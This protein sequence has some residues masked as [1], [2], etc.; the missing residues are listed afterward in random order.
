MKSDHERA[1]ERPCILSDTRLLCGNRLVPLDQ[2]YI[3]CYSYDI[4]FCNQR[5]IKIAIIDLRYFAYLTARIAV[6]IYPVQYTIESKK[7]NYIVTSG[8]RTVVSIEGCTTWSGLWD[9]QFINPRVQAC[10]DEIVQYCLSYNCYHEVHIQK[11]VSNNLGAHVSLRLIQLICYALKLQNTVKNYCQS[12]CTCGGFND[13]CECPIPYLCSEVF[14]DAKQ[15]H[16]NAVLF[17]ASSPPGE[18]TL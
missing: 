1:G 9:S 15:L 4:G 17:R 2:Y 13:E 8:Q 16:D 10:L 11:R 6:G 18:E 3:Y 7:L 14:V 5:I 12:N